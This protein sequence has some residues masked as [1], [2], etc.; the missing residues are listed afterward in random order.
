[1]VLDSGELKL[2][3]VEEEYLAGW[4]LNLT[5]GDEEEPGFEVR[6]RVMVGCDCEDDDSVGLDRYNWFDLEPSDDR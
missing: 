6:S 4:L 1:M 2:R 3:L 5:K